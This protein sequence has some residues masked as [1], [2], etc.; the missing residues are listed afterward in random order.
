[1]NSTPKHYLPLSRL[2]IILTAVALAPLARAQTDTTSTPSK[3]ATQDDIITLTPFT[4]RGDSAADGYRVDS[5]TTGAKI[6]TPLNE[7][8]ITINVLNREFL[9][10][11]NVYKVQDATAY[12]AGVT[13]AN[14]NE[15]DTETYTIRGFQSS[16]P[17]RNGIAFNSITDIS[18]IERVEVAKG[19][20]AI[21]YGVVEPGGVVN[22]TTKRP[23]ANYAATI[24]ETVGSY[25]LYR[26]DFDFNVPLNDSKTLLFRVPGAYSDKDTSQKYEK[27]KTFFINPVL[28]WKLTPKTLVTFD[29]S[30]KKETGNFARGGIIGALQPNANFPQA[31]SIFN[32]PGFGEEYGTSFPGGHLYNQHSYG[33][34][35]VEQII[36]SH[37]TL[38][39]IFSQDQFHFD[40]VSAFLNTFRTPAAANVSLPT[41]ATQLTSQFFPFDERYRTKSRYYEINALLRYD[42]GKVHTTTLLGVSGTRMVESEGAFYITPG[43]FPFTVDPSQPDAVRFAAMPADTS[44]F[45]KWF[46]YS[47]GAT[48]PGF[49]RA[50]LFVTEQIGAL[51]NKLHLMGGIRRQ[52]YADVNVTKTLP[53]IGGIYE[54]T[55]GLSFYATYSGTDK[56]NGLRASDQAVRPLETSKGYDFGFKL[57]LLDSKLTGSIAYFDIKKTNVKITNPGGFIDQTTGQI[58]PG[59]DNVLI[60]GEAEAK[61]VEVDLQA[62]PVKGLQLGLGYAHTDA[63]DTKDT[64][65]ALQGS[66]FPGVV[67]DALVFFGKFRVEGGVLANLDVGAGMQYNFGTV[68]YDAITNPF[69]G[70]ATH[71][72]TKNIHVFAH[73]PIVWDKHRVTLGLAVN[74]LTDDRYFVRSL[75]LSDARQVLFSAEVKF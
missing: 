54:V 53:Q 59:A 18:N 46:D 25:S 62:R 43:P 55:H 13:N 32:V 38:Q 60:A 21:L 28:T 36:D 75:E 72:N 20:A 42:L 64:D 70:I 35:R 2:L 30:Y 61:G 44:N 74:N 16:S 57:D 48:T 22:Y 23:L 67:K 41:S 29:Y 73:Y 65:P 47:L 49:G 19:P 1:M 66:T 17:L 63:K 9:T 37:I 14:R 68:H 3:K 39:G 40:D 31:V 45:V 12:V 56:S 5:T 6:N 7:L 50:N 11:M 34:I 8:P 27:S 10:D 58:L 51:D 33:E 71:G 52:S 24:E 4:V 15:N 26:T 69:Y